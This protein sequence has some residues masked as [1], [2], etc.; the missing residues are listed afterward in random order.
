MMLALTLKLSAKK[1][2]KNTRMTALGCFVNR[3]Y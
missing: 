3:L 2:N 1:Y